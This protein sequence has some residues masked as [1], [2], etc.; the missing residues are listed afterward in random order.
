MQTGMNI[1]TVVDKESLGAITD[2]L[3]TLM[4][5]KADQDTIRHAIDALGRMARVEGVTI[6]N[7]TIKGDSTVMVSV[8]ADADV[9]V[10]ED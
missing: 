1:G 8:D 4:A 3:V 7:C 9:S 10:R 5:Q 2:S 6:Q